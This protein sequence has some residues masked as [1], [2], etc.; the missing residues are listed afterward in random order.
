[1]I[2]FVFRINE[3]EV[4]HFFAQCN[5][6]AG[7]NGGGNK[8]KRRPKEAFSKE[9]EL[10]KKLNQERRKK[11]QQEQ[12]Q[13]QGEMDTDDKDEGEQGEEE[14]KPLPDILSCISKRFLEVAAS[15]SNDEGAAA[16][17]S[18]SGAAAATTASGAKEEEEE[19][20]VVDGEEE[21]KRHPAAFVEPEAPPNSVERLEE[22]T[23]SGAYLGDEDDDFLHCEDGAENIDLF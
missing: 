1:M 4:R 3:V 10:F 5:R 6:P 11:E 19:G 13:Q 2:F 18:S 15:G 16:A 21:G 7:A 9:L 12:Q 8:R 14:L 22:R 17:S 20:E 23:V